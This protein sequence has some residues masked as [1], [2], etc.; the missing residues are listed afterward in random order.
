[1]KQVLPILA[2]RMAVGAASALIGW[3]GA[4][5]AADEKAVEKAADNPAEVLELPTVEVIGTTPL[6]GLGTPVKDVPANVQVIT[7]KD[8]SKQHTLDLTD[9]LEQNPNSV[10]INSGQ[11][12]PF[13][14]DV[15]FRGFTA[16]PLLGTPQGISVFQD[17]VRINEPFGDS[18]NWDLIPQ[19]AISSIQV[20]P[21]SNPQFGLNTLGGALSIYT[22]SG[23][24]Y[25]G[26]SVEAYGGS[27]GRKSIEFETG[28]GF[29]KGF[30]YF[31]TANFLEE[32]GWRDFSPSRLKQAFAKVG[33][34][35]EKSDIDISFTLADN[36]LQ[37][38]QALPVSFLDRRKQAYTWPDITNNKLTFLNV[39]GSH[40]FTDDVLLGG[41]VYFRRLE[42]D[43]FNSNVNDAFDGMTSINQ[44]IN[45]RSSIE[46]NGYGGAIQLTLTQKLFAK[47]NQ[48]TVGT[49]TDWGD[50]KF[51]QESQPA[52]FTSD[53][54]TV[55]VGDFELQ[56]DVNTKNRYYG[57]YFTDTLSFSEAWSLTLS[58]RYNRAEVKIAD[59]SG[60]D[61]RLNGEHTFTR[62]NPAVGVNFNPIPKLTAYAT[63]NE[64]MRA[65]TPIELT[66]ADPNAPCKL[67]NNFLADPSLKKVVSK[68]IE[69]GSRGKFG[70][71][72]SWSAAAYR[73]NLAD[74]IQFISS[75]GAV[76]AGFFQNVGETRRQGLELT[77]GTKF[78]KLGLT[79]RYSYVDATFQSDFIVN[80]PNN[81]S[82][83][84]NGDIQV[85]AGNRIPGIARHSV[86][87]RLD[88]EFTEQ[89]SLGANILYSAGVFARGDENN[90][91]RNG[92]TSGY[93]IVNLDGRYQ[94][95]KKWQVF[96]RVTNLFD[97][98]YENFGV[99]GQNFF[100]TPDRTF[101]PSQGVDPQP[102][103]F[104][105][106]GAP[107]GIWVGAR[108]TF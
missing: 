32:T 90:Q 106:P 28:R 74:D 20:I 22:K 25:P 38:T 27:F 13:Q 65:P 10:S 76:N 11:V 47:K 3:T 31:L 21:G 105:S 7:T 66:C 93:T 48:F 41:N 42:T 60:V 69:V 108:Y 26:T 64:G 46:Q 50:V 15:N 33:W 57:I 34:Q 77:G 73:T 49:S 17:G 39:E 85:R 94:I 91:D 97:K 63:Y 53:R 80:S 75:G 89:L 51:R 4:G 84:G 5:L 62:F 37:G 102:E 8:I 79:A 23:L 44:A 92:E 6:P 56:T 67:P 96:G 98:N 70:E 58:G 40:F 14:Q 72:G 29:G 101:S 61:P 86:K 87:L 100:N 9:Y 19:S 2:R 83:D 30:D 55:A 104:R 52:D 95:G 103:Q 68:T 18:V 82:A 59:R 45:D 78:G 71:A 16:S 35:D 88:Y 24:Q 1:M 36:M 12:N 99:L 54:G 43:Q 107:R 81:S